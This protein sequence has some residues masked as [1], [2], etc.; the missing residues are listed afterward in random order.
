LCSLRALREKLTEATAVANSPPPRFLQTEKEQPPQNSTSF[1]RLELHNLRVTKISYSTINRLL[2]HT[3][4]R[5]STLH[6][7]SRDLY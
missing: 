5:P 2:F 1:P 4:S 3:L 7:R 6:R